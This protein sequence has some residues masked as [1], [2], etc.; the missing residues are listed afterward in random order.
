MQETSASLKRKQENTNQSGLFAFI[1]YSL[2][3]NRYKFYK[4]LTSVP[5]VLVNIVNRQLELRWH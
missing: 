3:S 4:L 5:S 2:E 1:I